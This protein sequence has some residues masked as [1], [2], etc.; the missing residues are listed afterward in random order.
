MSVLNKPILVIIILLNHQ[1]VGACLQDS[2]DIKSDI[3]VGNITTLAVGKDSRACIRIGGR[4][5]VQSVPSKV[6]TDNI[7]MIVHDGLSKKQLSSHFKP[8]D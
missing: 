5:V 3:K 6:K 7:H 8:C 2:T 4:G 1:N